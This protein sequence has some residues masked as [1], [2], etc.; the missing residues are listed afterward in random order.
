MGSTTEYIEL[1]SRS[2]FSFLEG[3]TTPEDLAD[4]AAELGYPAIAMGDRDGVYGHPRFYQAAKKAGVKAIVGADLTLEDDSRLYVLVPDRERY[5]NL[6]RMLTAS[7]C[8][9]LTPSS[10]PPFPT[11]EEE[12]RDSRSSPGERRAAQVGVQPDGT[13]FPIYPLK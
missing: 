9:V 7:K 4:R 12:R 6:C 1:R 5:K 8:R 2:A 3:A 13:S 11:G 10:P